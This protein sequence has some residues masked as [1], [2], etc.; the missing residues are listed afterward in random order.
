MQDTLE[1]RRELRD[2]VAEHRDPD[3]DIDPLFVNRW[4]PRAMTGD[5]LDEEEYL[6]LFEAARWAP[7][8]FNNQHWRFLVA[9]R[10]DEEWDA[11]LDLLS[12]N[13]RAWAS[14]AAVL[15]VIVSKTTFDHNGEPAPV[16]SF[17]TGAAWENLALEGARRGLAVHGMAGFDYERAAEE[18]DVPEEYA[19]EA[20]VAIGERAPPETLPE[21]LQD[22]EQPS[23][24]KPLE[25]IVH[26]GGFE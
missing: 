19:V 16:H 17:D 26:R 3:H 15:A 24:R 6:P 14:D 7:S 5:P 8:A 2:E 18:L 9:D 4:S 23:D 10:E 22:R 21:E 25:E 12:E 1:S 11:F 20:M 13:N